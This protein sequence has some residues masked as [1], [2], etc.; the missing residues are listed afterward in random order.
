MTNVKESAVLFVLFIFA[1]YFLVALKK[2]KYIAFFIGVII[3]SLI[4]GVL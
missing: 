4:S 3:F 1:I 2:N